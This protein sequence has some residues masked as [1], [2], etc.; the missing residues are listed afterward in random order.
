MR[1]GQ[2]AWRSLRERLPTRVPDRPGTLRWDAGELAGYPYVGVGPSD[3]ARRPRRPPLVVIPGLNDPLARATEHR[4]FDALLA[5][6]CRR[7]ARERPVYAVSRPPGLPTKRTTREMAAGYVDVLDAV[8]RGDERVDLLGL[9]MGGFV[10][11]HLAADFPERVNRVVFGLAAHA[12]AERGAAV[13]RRWRRY[14]EMERW[15]AVELEAVDLVAR[16]PVARLARLGARGH[17]ALSKGLR[18]PADFLVSA[19]ACLAHDGWS[20]LSE[21]AAPTLVVGGTADPFFDA[22]DFRATAERLPAGSLSLLDGV[23]HEAVVG[24]HASFDDSIR[25]FLA[26]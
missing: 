18:A 20:R 15:L 10:V 13:V 26:E 16:G 14:A 7:F 6:F 12:L 9:S 21:I 2:G 5:A 4:W 3:G 25:R 22:D 11:Q 8:R 19:D 1:G 17:V 23:G 24:D